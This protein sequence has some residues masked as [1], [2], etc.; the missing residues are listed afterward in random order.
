MK[1]LLYGF[2]T[3]CLALSVR[4]DNASDKSSADA[5]VQ[6]SSDFRVAILDNSH[7][8]LERTAMHEAFAASLAKAMTKQCGGTV[9]VKVSEVDA[10]T[11][12]FDMK[13]GSYDAAFI[14]GNNVPPELR[15]GDFEIL[16]ATSDVGGPARRFYMVVPTNDASM[17]RAVSASFPDAL[18][19]DKFQESVVHAVAIHVNPAAVQE[20]AKES[21][22][23]ST[24]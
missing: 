4:A 16:R 6:A 11:L 23:D 5:S 7:P 15:R 3:A 17:E 13:S 2:L 24:R 18:A 12:A 8:S 1:A 21:V 10:F 22:A 20:A 14:V 19:S 9:N